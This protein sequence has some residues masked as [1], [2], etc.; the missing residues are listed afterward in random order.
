MDSYLEAW[1]DQIT[2]KVAYLEDENA[3][4]H[5]ATDKRQIQNAVLRK[6]ICCGYSLEASYWDASNAYAQQMLIC[7]EK[8]KKKCHLFWLMKKWL[9]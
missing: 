1:T 8:Y 6:D 9:I 2:S 7:L 4:I 5:M 3:M